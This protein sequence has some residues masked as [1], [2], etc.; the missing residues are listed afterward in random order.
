M[1]LKP[2][3]VIIFVIFSFSLTGCQQ[4]DKFNSKAIEKPIGTVLSTPDK[5]IIYNKDKSKELDKN[6]SRFGKIVELTNKRFHS[7]LSTALDIIDE[8]NSTS[9]NRDGY[10]IEFIF[11]MSMNYL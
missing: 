3:I 7:K 5:I 11:L 4:S 10:G 8:G 6:D 1:K 2:F 9:I